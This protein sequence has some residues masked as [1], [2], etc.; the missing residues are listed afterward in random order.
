MA[1]RFRAEYMDDKLQPVEADDFLLQPE[2][3]T[4]DAAPVAKRPRG[5]E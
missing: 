1:V 5:A 3:V 4:S 2:F